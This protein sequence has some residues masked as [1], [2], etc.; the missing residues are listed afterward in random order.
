LRELHRGARSLLLLRVF[1]P[2]L[3]P[4]LLFVPGLGRVGPHPNPRPRAPGALC[5][6]PTFR[7]P[8][9]VVLQ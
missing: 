5:H 9:C 2:A 3:V 1:M 4:L 6:C 8:A 7:L